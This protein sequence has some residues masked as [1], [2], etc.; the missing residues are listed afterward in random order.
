[1]KHELGISHMTIVDW[2]NFSREVCISILEKISEQIGGPGKIV[3]I[4]ESKF[5]K[6]TLHKGRKVDGMLVITGIEGLQEVFLQVCK[7]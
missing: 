4:D 5:G 2:Y 6:R 3:E 1:M 7:R